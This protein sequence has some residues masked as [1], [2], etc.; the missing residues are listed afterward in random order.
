MGQVLQLP[1]LHT[2]DLPAFFFLIIL[3]IIAVTIAT[4]TAQMMIVQMLPDI[5]A[6]ISSAPFLPLFYGLSAKIAEV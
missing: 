5:H 6:S 3:T 4:S 2:M 1:Q